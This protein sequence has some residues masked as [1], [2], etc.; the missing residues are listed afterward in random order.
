MLD[1]KSGCWWVSS[2]SGLGPSLSHLWQ[3]AAQERAGGCVGESSHGRFFSLG[4]LWAPS[5]LSCPGCSPTHQIW[6]ALPSHYQPPPPAPPPSPWPQLCSHSR[7]RRRPASPPLVLTTCQPAGD[8]SPY[9][10]SSSILPA[11]T[12]SWERGETLCDS[13]AP[14]L[15]VHSIIVVTLPRPQNRVKTAPVPPHVQSQKA[16]RSGNRLKFLF[17]CFWKEKPGSLSL[18]GRRFLFHMTQSQWSR[19][20]GVSPPPRM[21]KLTM[22]NFCK[23]TVLIQYYWIISFSQSSNKIRISVIFKKEDVSPSSEQFWALLAL[24]GILS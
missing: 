4:H 13:L 12:T 14:P 3:A 16:G 21:H 8:C 20:E 23:I 2:R 18:L 24:L 15:H 22:R 1:F 5:P 7:C 10:P 6:S 17:K 19:Q 9:S 11:P